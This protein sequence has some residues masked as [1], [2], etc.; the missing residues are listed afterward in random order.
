MTTRSALNQRARI[1]GER[2]ARPRPDSRDYIH[3]AAHKA[4]EAQTFNTIAWQ[5]PRSVDISGVRLIWDRLDDNYGLMVYQGEGVLDLGALTLYADQ[6]I[7]RSPLRFPGT[8]VTIHARELIFEGDGSIDTTPRRHLASKASTPLRKD[9]LPTYVAADGA[10]GEPA[11][12]IHLLIHTL[13]GADPGGRRRFIA[14]GSN[15]QVGE[16]GD[17]LKYKPRL[18]DQPEAEKGKDLNPVELDTLV[19]HINEKFVVKTWFWPGQVREAKDMHKADGLK[20]DK[21]THVRLIARDDG[22]VTCNVTRT[23]FPG[24]DM[25]G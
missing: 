21:A 18:T 13:R 24:K 11:G 1:L 6:V 10:H 14:V 9:G 22:L 17:Y 16:D 19:G 5:E 7:I 8:T 12:D 2:R 3:I 20:N 4:L 23:Y 25:L 15:G